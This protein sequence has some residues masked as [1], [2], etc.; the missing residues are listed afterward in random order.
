MHKSLLSAQRLLE[1]TWCEQRCLVNVENVEGA[2]SGLANES[3]AKANSL[4]YIYISHAFINRATRTLHSTLV[5]LKTQDAVAVVDAP[6]A[7]F[8]R[9][10][11]RDFVEQVFQS[12]SWLVLL[13]L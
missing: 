7:L 4:L 3:V 8:A 11:W 13:D 1:L 12:A 10:L 2:Q 5:L 6:S 9:D